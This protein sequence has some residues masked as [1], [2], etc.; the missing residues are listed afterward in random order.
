M[1]TLVGLGYFDE[2][3]AFA[4]GVFRNNTLSDVLREGGPE[5]MKC[6]IGLCGDEA[7]KATSRLLDAARA[8]FSQ[9]NDLDK[10][11]TAANVA[12]GFNGDIFEWFS[13]SEG[14]WR[15]SR[16]GKAMKQLHHAINENVADGMHHLLPVEGFVIF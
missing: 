12:L 11:I 2:V 4:S 5:S 16:L 15:N 8:N 7:F 13:N 3:G 1:S 9:I 14:Q 6:A 10:R